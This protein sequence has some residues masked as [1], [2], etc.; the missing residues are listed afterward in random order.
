MF[1]L[2]APLSGTIMKLSKVPDKVF[3]SKMAGEGVAI[4]SID[5]IVVAPADGQLAFI[6]EGNHA[7]CMKLDNG[8]LIIVHI[9]IDTV[10]LKGDGFKRLTEAG[11]RVK[12]GDPIIKIDRKKVIEKGYSLITPVLITNMNLV[13]EMS[14]TSLV[15]A[16]AGRDVILAY[17]IK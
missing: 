17:K 2:F 6:L 15:K 11:V 8:I 4:D 14:Y 5:D 9:G 3:A 7:F 10:E 1:E 12:V 13:S 16:E